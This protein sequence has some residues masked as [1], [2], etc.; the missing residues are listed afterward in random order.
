M[1][2]VLLGTQNIPFT[3]LLEK[4]ESMDLNQNIIVQA[5]FTKFY[6]KKM[7][8]FDYK[9]KEEL[10]VLIKKADL[11]ITHAGVGSIMDGVLNNKK[12]IAVPRL[13]K[14]NEHVNNHQ[15]QIVKSFSELGYLK[16]VYDLNELEKE[17][18]NIKTF[19]PKKFK[20][21]LKNVLSII[22]DFIDNN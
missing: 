5:G 4:L 13:K 15:L 20:S 19:I 16:A 11:I 10:I 9:K 22:E 6:S 14:Y 8:I 17:I 3:R 2:L 7:E 18:L 21:N 1:I 12:V